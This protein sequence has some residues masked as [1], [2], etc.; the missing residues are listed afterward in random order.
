MTNK[1]QIDFCKGLIKN[2][3][4]E[5]L[6]KAS[7]FPSGWEGH[8]LRRYISDSFKCV[9]MGTLDKKRLKDYRNDVIINNL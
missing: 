6:S 8:E 2:V 1:E 7:L 5:I 4:R 3:Q 9:D